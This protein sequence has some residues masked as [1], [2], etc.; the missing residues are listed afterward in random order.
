MAKSKSTTKFFI[1]Q[2][3]NRN[4]STEFKKGKVNDIEKGICTIKM[5]SEAYKVSRTSV[6]KWIYLYSNIEKG[7]KTVVQ[8]ESEEIK[9]KLAFEKIGELE[10]IIGQKQMMIDYLEKLIEITSNEIG[11]DV[12]KK[13]EQKALNGLEHTR[14]I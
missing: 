6:Y 8:M 5:V 13:A 4:F 10:R 1:D 14:K 9:T 2:N 7:V 12:K 11:Y 3:H